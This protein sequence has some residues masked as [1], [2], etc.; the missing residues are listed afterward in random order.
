VF[1]HPLPRVAVQPLADVLLQVIQALVLVADVL[2]Q[3]VVELRRLLFLHG[4]DLDPEADRASGELLALELGGVFLADRLLFPRLHAHKL[5]V[6]S[7][8][9]VAAAHLEDEALP[10]AA[11]E[12]GA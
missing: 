11:G 9:V 7:V 5:L 6:D 12:V 2:R 3:L 1:P 10:P 8:Q 4:I